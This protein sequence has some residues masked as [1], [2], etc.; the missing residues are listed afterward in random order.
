MLAFAWPQAERKKRAN[1]NT[2]P[3]KLKKRLTFFRAIKQ[4]FS[5]FARSHDCLSDIFSK[6][7]SI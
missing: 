5:H 2:I 4:L 6:F 1:F 7:F 3:T